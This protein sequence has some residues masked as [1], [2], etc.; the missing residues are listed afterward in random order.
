MTQNVKIKKIKEKE[1][2]KMEKAR[3]SI[4]KE[5]DEPL[6]MLEDAYEYVKKEFGDLFASPIKRAKNKNK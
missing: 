1:L 4:N 2:S 6:K 3:K 5:R